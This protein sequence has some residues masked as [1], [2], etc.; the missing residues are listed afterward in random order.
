[1]R[2]RVASEKLMWLH[3][4]QL[5][6]ITFGREKVFSFSNDFSSSRILVSSS[7]FL[8]P[9]LNK[10]I[11]LSLFSF[12]IQCDQIR[13]LLLLVLGN[14]VSC[15]SIPSIFWLFGLFWKSITF[16][17]NSCGYFWAT[18]GKFKILLVPTFGHTASIAVKN[19][20]WH[21]LFGLP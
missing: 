6:N 18:F 9:F 5:E 7:F 10:S 17:K 3:P 20:D 2:W 4:S 14:K 21:K 19:C 11:F 13:Q 8:F 12:S 1:M 15:N 16:K